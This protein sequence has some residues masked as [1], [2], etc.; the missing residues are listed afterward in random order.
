[1]TEELEFNCQICGLFAVNY[2]YHRTLPL[3]CTH[4]VEVNKLYFICACCW[5]EN[6]Q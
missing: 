4:G 2:I 5:G 1:M 3:Q 6:K